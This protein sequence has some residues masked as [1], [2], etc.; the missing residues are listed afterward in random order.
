MNSRKYIYV[1]FC[2]FRV[3]LLYHFFQWIFGQILPLQRQSMPAFKRQIYVGE[4][5]KALLLR[6]II[7]LC[8]LVTMCGMEV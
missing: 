6:W 1:S 8:I 2:V 7:G 4:P 5:G 3:I